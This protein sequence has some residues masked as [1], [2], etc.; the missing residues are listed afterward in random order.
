M[1]D[2]PFTLPDEYSWIDTSNRPFN[3]ALTTALNTDRFLFVSGKAGSGKSLLIKIISTMIK[4]TIVLST[5]G[6]TAMELCTDKIAAKTI[7]SFMS[8]P[9]IPVMQQNDLFFISHKS[10]QLLNKAELI[11]IDEVS[12]MSNHLF[13][14]LCKKIERHRYDHQIPRMILFGD[15]MQLTPVI[16]SNKIV[17]DFYD[18]EYNGKVMFFN[19][20]YFKQLN[21]KTVYL[22]KSFRHEE[23]DFADHIREIGFRDHTQETL[24]YFNQRVMPL[25]D[26]EKIHKHYIYMSP[27][28]RVVDKVNSDYIKTLSGKNHIYVAS[29]SKNYPKDK[30][31]NSDS[32]EIKVGSQVMCLMNAADWKDATKFYTN[33]MIGE[34]IG[35]EPECAIIRLADGQ[36]R[37]IGKSTLNLYDMQLDSN[38]NIEYKPIAWYK[39]ID[40][41]IA[42]ALTCHRSQGKT[43]NAAYMSLQGWIPEGITYVGLSRVRTLG[44]L[45]LS[46]P[47]RES[48]IV[49]NEES[50]EFL[51]M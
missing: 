49:V 28:N 48:D 40:C 17:R 29:M 34:V 45:G 35:L 30:K 50:Y 4:N 27:T 2:I 11:I 14:T 39:Q 5:T 33:G 10:K 26:F 16:D 41:K 13:D 37:N 8:L 32:V 9:P 43:F 15:V 22:R 47:L 7:H 1:E 42:R 25:K 20:H 38:G 12:M 23:E 19:S 51:T 3:D 6:T 31:P 21:F 46:R 36:E 18:A 24:D 44:G